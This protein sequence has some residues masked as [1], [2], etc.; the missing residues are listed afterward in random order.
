MN[1]N[2]ALDLLM[3]SSEAMHRDG[4]PLMRR[5]LPSEQDIV[6]WHH[7]PGVD[8]VNGAHASR[9]FYHCHPVEE[10][11]N[12]EHG[13]FHIFIGKTAFSK[14]VR[15]MISPPKKR[16]TPK[17]VHVAALSINA[18]GLPVGWFTTNRWVTGEWMYR[19]ADIRQLLPLIDFRGDA[20][21]PLVNDWLTAIV[22]LSFDMIGVLLDQRDAQIMAQDPSGENEDLE[23]A[24]QAAID[25]A[26]LLD[27]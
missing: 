10:R 14:D 16:N 26:V 2:D 18:A 1:R 23:I 17:V 22:H 13:H 15:P 7:Y 25:L 4:T 3:S 6:L 20:G 11:G 12:G 24:S 27:G 8:I 19:A 21:D 9:Y 5:I